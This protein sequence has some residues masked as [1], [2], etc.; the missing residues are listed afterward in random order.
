MK[1]LQEFSLLSNKQILS[2]LRETFH[3][4][5][6]R[7]HEKVGVSVAASITDQNFDIFRDKLKNEVQSTI[8]P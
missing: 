8:F 5:Q 6:D 1:T 2:K 7:I 3:R 4:L